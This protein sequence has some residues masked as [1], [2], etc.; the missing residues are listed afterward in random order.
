MREP[1]D[2]L[3]V[4]NLATLIELK[5]AARRHRD[6]G[7]VV[8]LIRVQNLDESFLDRLHPSVHQDYIECL[9]EKRREDEY[10]S[11]Q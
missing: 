3:Q 11:Q 5:L 4:V 9:E 1:I 7:D 8:D 2:N 6:F 10:E